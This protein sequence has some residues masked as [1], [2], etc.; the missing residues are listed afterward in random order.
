VNSLKWKKILI[1]VD[2]LIGPDKI[3]LELKRC[4]DGIKEVIV[5]VISLCFF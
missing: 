1:T 5:V 2:F 4:K 3:T